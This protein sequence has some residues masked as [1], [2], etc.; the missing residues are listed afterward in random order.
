MGRLEARG[1]PSLPIE[2]PL[3]ALR[4]VIAQAGRVDLLKIDVEGAEYPIL[5]DTEAELFASVDRIVL[6]Y[7][8]QAAGSERTGADLAQRLRS[9]GY[10][11]EEG[12]EGLAKGFGARIMSAWR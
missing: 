9:L 5:L 11:V 6:E 2:V 12:L 4:D 10:S 7:D 8:A 1:T 3:I